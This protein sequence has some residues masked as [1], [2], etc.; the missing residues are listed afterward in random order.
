MENSQ[1]QQPVILDDNLIDHSSATKMQRFSA[2]LIDIIISFSFAY[3]IPIVGSLLSVAYYLNKD[4]FPFLNGQSL[5]KKLF[6]IRVVSTND[7][8]P[9]TSDYSA[10][11]L[12]SVTVLIP[13]INFFESIVVLS[14]KERFGDKWAGTIVLKEKPE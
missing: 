10:S 5:G 1:Y 14:G 12:R 6:Q 7:N 11:I 9:I 2:G 8:H 4:A 13:I 3:L